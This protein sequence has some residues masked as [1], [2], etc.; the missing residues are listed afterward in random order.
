VVIPSV[1]SPH[2]T[3]KQVA[4]WLHCSIRTVH[5]RT[6]LGEIPFWK[7]SGGR[8]C[9]FL[10]EE[11]AAWRNGAALEDVSLPRGGRRVRPR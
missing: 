1:E 7:P 3:A 4:D 6:R 11:L 10:E 2:M 5:E 8:R 9:L